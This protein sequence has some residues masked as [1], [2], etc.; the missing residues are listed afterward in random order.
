V[1]NL[2]EFP[3]PN[4]CD[5]SPRRQSNV[6][7]TVCR[8]GDEV[9]R[10]KFQFHGTAGCVSAKEN[11]SGVCRNLVQSYEELLRERVEVL[12]RSKA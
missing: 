10:C 6:M 2:L 12:E 5:W 9:W 8:T 11:G 1:R 4:L 3:D 7:N